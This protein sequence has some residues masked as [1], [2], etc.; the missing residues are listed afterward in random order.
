MQQYFCDTEL[1]I[2]S[3]YVFTDAQAH[4]A[5]DVVR[6]DHETV[7]LVYNEKGFFGTCY[8]KGKQFVCMVEKEDPRM[9]ELQADITL[10]MALI[11]R[12]KFELVLQKATELGVSRIIPFESS[13]CVVHA[14]KEKSD[15]LM[16]RWQDTVHS[17]AEQ[18]KR[19]RIPAIMPVASFDDLMNISDV[20]KLCAYENAYGTSKTLSEI[21][22]Q[23][24]SVA[25]AIGPEGGFSENEVEKLQDS[26]YQSV[27]FGSR[28]LRAETAAFYACSVLSEL[29]DGE[30]K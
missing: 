27:T 1:K 6:L 24:K 30:K 9:N 3:E 13:R 18:C 19:N 28:I 14:K 21:Y 23:E 5:R 22:T 2:G 25:V 12:E 29:T 11:R 7:R 16:E 20:L 4:H 17:A 10:C 15:R 8:A 26:G